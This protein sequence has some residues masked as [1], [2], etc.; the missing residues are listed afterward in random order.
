MPGHDRE[1]SL[2]HLG[3]AFIEHFFRHGPGPIGGKP[4]R[5]D[6]H[7]YDLL[8]D[9]YALEN[10]GRR[11][12]MTVVVSAPKGT[13]KSE[14]AGA[15]TLFEVYGPSR[16]AGWAKGGEVY[17]Q[18]DFRYVYQPGEPMG[19]RIRD[20][21]ARLLATEE[22]QT[23]NTYRN[24]RANLSQGYPLYEHVSGYREFQA[25]KTMAMLPGNAQVWPSTAG[26]ASKDGGLE[27][28]AVADETHLYITDELRDMYETVDQN[29]PKRGL[30][31]E[32]WML[33]TTTMYRAGQN[34]VAEQQHK[35]ALAI[36]AGTVPNPGLLYDHIEGGTIVDLAETD[37]LREVLHE[38]YADRDWIN[39]DRYVARAQDPTKDPARFRRYYLNQQAAG[40]EA[41]VTSNELN[42]VLGTEEDPIAPLKKGET[43]TVG[44]D[45]APGNRDGSGKRRHF[46]V[47]D[48]TALIACR[49]SDMTLHK[50][51]L[52]EADEVLAKKE[53][54]NPPMVEIDATVHEAFAKYD[55][56][57]FFADPSG[58]ESYLDRWTA[59][60][61]SRLKIKASA[62]RPMYR[63]MSGKSATQSG[64][65]V[66]ALYEA[67]ATQQVRIAPDPDLIRHF[68]NA[69]R[70]SG[71]FGTALY[72]ANPDS[73]RKID[74]AVTC[75][76]AYAPAVL[77]LNKGIGLIQAVRGRARKIR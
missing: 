19:R 67:I 59:K 60:Y 13:S 66:D 10:T 45:Y 33:A 50:L 32:P 17:E 27:T 16:F 42:A 26:A 25:G 52:W 3:A 21:Y 1:R 11:L 29:L 39:Y 57:A 22:G 65:D 14:F 40:A 58:I 74:A 76:L 15:V 63:Y 71:K 44:F 9:A 49:I 54:W 12:Y 24:V 34:S 7:F 35:L 38:A 56:V 73:P 8:T 77:A 43:I 61:L 70:E 4:Y 69:R 36:Q 64:K 37:R 75:V 31:D 53:G 62:E 20:P 55:V 18:H 47:P 28:F 5:L 48:S 23:G 51:G 72:K 41:Y 2:G 68:L 30:I 6:D 46:R